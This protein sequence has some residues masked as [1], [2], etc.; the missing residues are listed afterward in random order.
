[1]LDLLSIFGLILAFLVGYQFPRKAGWGVL[2]IAPVLGP[3]T[4]TFVPSSLLPLTTY[5]VAFAITMGVILRNHDRHGIPLSSIFKSTFVKVV[6][7]FSL[8]IILISLEDRLKNIMFTYI[9]KLILAFALCYILI[10]D[11]KD[12]Q[13]LVKIFVWQAALICL[14]IVLEVYTDFDIGVILRKTIPGYDITQLQSKHFNF[15]IRSGYFRATGLYGSGVSTGYA[16]AFL[17]P[18]TL[19]YSIQGKVLNKFPIL[20]VIVGLVLMQPRAALVGIFVALLVLLM[21]IILLKGKKIIGK[22][23]AVTKLALILIITCSFLVLFF[24]SIPEKASHVLAESIQYSSDDRDLTMKGKIDRIPIAIDYFLERPF[25]GYGSPQYAYS[26]VMRCQDL[27][28]PLIYL[29]AGGIPLCLLYLIMIFYMPYSVFRL[30]RRKGL[31]SGQRVFLTYAVAAFVGGV[32]VVFSNRVE[33]HFMIMYM[34][35]IS[36]YKVYVYRGKP[37]RI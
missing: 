3:A 23:K 14:F 28:A 21:G 17:F 8:F 16:L 34:L 4:F 5:R 10:R 35:Y 7:V 19:L 15:S 6:V 2:L 26:K 18:L 24:P 31:N 13:R 32:V 37:T 36:I 9:P 12:L 33:A 1:M 25:T 20:L 27:P 29:L 11:E 22:I 30:S